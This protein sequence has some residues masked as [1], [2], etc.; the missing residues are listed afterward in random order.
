MIPK[1]RT[2]GRPKKS[3]YREGRKRSLCIRLS[4]Q[5]LKKLEFITDYY[6]ISKTDFLI[7]KI[8]DEVHDISR[9]ERT[10]G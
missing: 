9:R 5:D 3:S 2:T 6:G 1:K 8:D 7:M 10:N 4:D